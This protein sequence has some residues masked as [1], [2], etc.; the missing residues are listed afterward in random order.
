[1]QCPKQAILATLRQGRSRK[2]HVHDS[3][4]EAASML[5]RGKW[6]CRERLPSL[7]LCPRRRYLHGAMHSQ[8]THKRDAVGGEGQARLWMVSG[9]EDG[10]G[11]AVTSIG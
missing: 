7:L 8:R 2:Q 5:L 9:G 3:E 11:F 1:M 6:P 4:C 10:T